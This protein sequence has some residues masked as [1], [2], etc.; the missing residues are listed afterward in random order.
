[1]DGGVLEYSESAMKVCS[2]AAATFKEIEASTA[3]FL[4]QLEVPKAAK[5]LYTADVQKVV[6]EIGKYIETEDFKKLMM[7]AEDKVAKWKEL[8]AD[9]L[10][11]LL[12]RGRARTG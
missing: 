4:A 2:G 3:K 12:G 10:S 1:M 8:F 7:R 11:E 9:E 5:T 6:V